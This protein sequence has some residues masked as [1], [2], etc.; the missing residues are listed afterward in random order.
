MSNGGAGSVY[1]NDNDN[2]DNDNEYS[3]TCDKE[4]SPGHWLATY[5]Q[6]N[7]TRDKQY[8]MTTFVY[9]YYTITWKYC[10]F[11]SCFHSVSELP[12]FVYHSEKAQIYDC[13][14]FNR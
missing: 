7:N 10:N 4:K 9:I 13:F 6:H 5:I 11:R 1:D 14:L 12:N 3:Y 2:D 8:K